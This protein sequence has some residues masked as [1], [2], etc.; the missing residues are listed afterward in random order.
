MN[1]L[2]LFASALTALLLLPAVTT[3]GANQTWLTDTIYDNTYTPAGLT[4]DNDVVDGATLAVTNGGN[5]LANSLNVGPNLPASA[6]LWSASSIRLTTLLATNNTL[7]ATNS[8]LELRGGTLTTAN[9]GGLATEYAVPANNL[10]LIN[11]TWNMLG[12][13]HKTYPVQLVEPADTAIIGY[14]STGLVVV[15]NSLWDAGNS[16]GLGLALQIGNGPSAQ[17]TLWIGNGGVVSN[18]ALPGDYAIK[19]GASGSSSNSIVITNG[20]ILHMNG[21]GALAIGV[22]SDTSSNNSVVVTGSGSALMMNSHSIR[23]GAT[24]TS[25]GNSL[26]LENGALATNVYNLWIGSSSG[27]AAGQNNS[28][29]LRGGSKYYLNSGTADSVVGNGVNAANNTLLISGANSLFDNSSKSILVGSGTG[30]NNNAII[31]DAGTLTVNNGNLL[32]GDADCFEN[33]IIVTNGGQIIGVGTVGYGSGASNNAVQLGGNGGGLWDARGGTVTVGVS[34][35]VSNYIS[36]GTGGVLSNALTISLGAAGSDGSQVIGNGGTIVARSSGA[37]TIPNSAGGTFLVQAGGLTFDDNSRSIVMRAPIAEDSASPGGSV[38]K[39]GSGSLTLTNV[40]TFTGGLYIKSGRV[41]TQNSRQSLGGNG[42]GTVFLGDTSGGAD[43]SLENLNGGAFTNSIVVQ[44]GN[45]GT[46]LMVGNGSS[47]NYYGAITNNHPRF[48]LSGGSGNAF[49]VLRGSVHGSST[50]TVY[51]TNAVLGT[52]VWACDGSDY[53]GT[54]V[55]SNSTLRMGG[56]DLLALPNATLQVNPGAT[57]DVLLTDPA[58]GGLTDLAGAGGLIWCASAISNHTV[59]LTGAGNYSFAGVIRNGPAATAV[60]TNSFLS[61]VKDGPGVQALAGANT[62][63]GTTV[64]NNGT[65]LINGNSLGVTNI[66]TVA[67]GATLGGKGTLGGAVIFQAGAFATNVVGSPL[68]VAAPVTL[69]GNA[70][71]VSTLS[72]LGT[73]SYLLLTNTAGGITGAFATVNVSGAGVSGTPSIV[74]TANAVLLNVGAGLP[75][76]PTNVT[77]SVTAGDTLNLTWPPSYTGWELQ[78]NSVSLTSP[79]DWSLVP[80]STATNAM[81]FGVDQTKS[82]VFFRLRHP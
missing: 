67:S 6:Q 75:S 8:T 34:G 18:F 13:E 49:L 70:M 27:T 36:L 71:N 35:A 57:N 9:A 32:V 40:G 78:S 66:T 81:S 21:A 20:G 58:V 25:S 63:G 24:G 64:V 19:L 31:V 14:Y 60:A 50:I 33:S 72:T 16:S 30:A 62:Y 28:V 7:T 76:T 65:L 77:F 54:L 23:V 47:P 68:T 74:T 10:F 17:G 1:T 43:V 11:G 22:T 37:T 3:H 41:I 55:V 12:G 46:P 51:N 26:I 45:T 38:T 29:Q 5:L 42:F 53:T 2:R 4:T 39:I 48:T 52:V 79:S 82:K 80:G 59:F 15:S 73:G 56:G 69:N 44:A 61:I